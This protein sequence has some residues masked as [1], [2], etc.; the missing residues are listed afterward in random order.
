VKSRLAL[1]AALSTAAILAAP[2]LANAATLT[3]TP[4][5][6][7]Y[8]GGGTVNPETRLLGGEPIVVTGSGFTPNGLVTI[9]A[10][11]RTLGDP[12]A[13]AAGNFTGTYRPTVAR[14]AEVKNL[15]ATDQTNPA[16]TAA[17]RLQVS[18]LTVNLKPKRG[19]P[20]RRFRIGARGF[21][22][23]RRLYAHIVRGGRVRRTVRIGRLKGPCHKLSAR[24]RLFRRNVGTGLY[25]IQF[26]S[27]RRYSKKTKVKI[28][29][30]FEVTRRSR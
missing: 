9:A 24:R 30:G 12:A 11:G 27:K 15:T 3:A 6:S 17:V 23:G 5:K 10:N 7:C 21:T 29:R 19:R 26:D 1:V 18:A 14:G 22:T 16:I 13:D 28:V 2:A 4:A 25:R 20:N 8:R